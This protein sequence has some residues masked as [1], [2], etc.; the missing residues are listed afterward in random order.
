[1]VPGDVAASILLQATKL[2]DDAFAD[3][4]QRAASRRDGGD[5][6]GFLRWRHRWRLEENSASAS[7]GCFDRLS[8]SPLRRYLVMLLLSVTVLQR[9]VAVVRTF[10]V[11]VLPL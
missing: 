4:E 8:L 9:R 11:Y 5:K 7:L 2:G 1:M 3:S 10:V 6:A